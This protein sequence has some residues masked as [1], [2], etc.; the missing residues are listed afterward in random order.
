MIREGEAGLATHPEFVDG[1]DLFPVPGDGSVTAGDID[2]MSSVPSTEVDAANL[3]A[4]AECVAAADAAAA[5]D[6][7]PGSRSR[8]GIT[9]HV[10]CQ[11]KRA[12]AEI[13]KVVGSP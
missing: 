10:L 1:D 2:I 11:L 13:T 12:M 3:G 5:A 4:P 6:I 7:R 9:E 8:F